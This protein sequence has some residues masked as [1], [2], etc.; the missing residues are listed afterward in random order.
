[1]KNEKTIRIKITD[2]ELEAILCAI[3]EWQYQNKNL[4]DSES[5]EIR[6]ALKRAEKK[7]RKF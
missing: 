2:N 6:K 7:L 4:K 5:V 3:F 1:M